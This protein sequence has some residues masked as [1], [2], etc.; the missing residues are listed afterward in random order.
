MKRT[1]DLLTP[2]TVLPY[3]AHRGI[4]IGSDSHAAE[5]GGGV[6]NV[7]IR[8]SG[9]AR[10]VIVKQSLP[11]LKVEADWHAPIERVITEGRALEYLAR[12]VP[13]LVPEVLDVDESAFALTISCAPETWPDWKQSMMGGATVPGIGSRLGAGLGSLHRLSRSAELPSELLDPEPF[14]LLRLQPYYEEAA[15]FVPELAEEIHAQA[16]V[17]RRERTCLVHGDLS[18]KNILV[19]PSG[20]ELWVIDLEVAHLGN[21]IFDVAFLLTHL[22]MKAVHL[23]P[24]R[25][26]VWRQASEFLEAYVA[27]SRAD[28][29]KLEVAAMAQVGALLL[30]R[31]YGKSTAE[32][33]TL[34][35]RLIVSDTGRMLIRGEIS[36]L[37]TLSRLLTH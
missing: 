26:Y 23:P 14:E 29:R 21:P 18:P 25:T 3:L 10:A 5:L 1:T 13:D 12:T 11:Q 34:S 22:T 7:V 32:Y 30:A 15:L 36:D 8:A 28:D 24:S 19:S 37:R 33:L 9:S 31:V 20:G 27:A 6:S 35:E 2:D 4:E 16:D 17:L